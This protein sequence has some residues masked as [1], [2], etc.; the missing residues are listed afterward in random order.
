MF[1]LKY[2]IFCLKELLF[3]IFVLPCVFLNILHIHNPVIIC[4]NTLML[5]PPGKLAIFDKKGFDNHGWHPHPTPP[6]Q[7]MLHDPNSMSQH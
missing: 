4:W 5:N 7:A 2:L 6:H 1:M 3:M